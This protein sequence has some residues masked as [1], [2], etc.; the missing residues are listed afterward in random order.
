MAAVPRAKA[1]VARGR[2]G[3][4]ENSPRGRVPQS[5]KKEGVAVVVVMLTITMKATVARTG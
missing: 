5:T 1:W 2:H 4:R 3:D